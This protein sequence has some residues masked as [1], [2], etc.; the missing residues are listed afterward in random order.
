MPREHVH[1][2]RLAELIRYGDPRLAFVA[3]AWHAAIFGAL[4]FA[5][6]VV[7]WLRPATGVEAEIYASY[8]IVPPWI[9]GL[10][11][12]AGAF[13]VAYAAAGGGR[14]AGRIGTMVI[15]GG[16]IYVFVTIP[17]ASAA[18]SVWL[19][20]AFAR[21]GS[22]LAVAL[23]AWVRASHSAGW[24]GPSP[25][26][27]SPTRHRAQYAAAMVVFPPAALALLLDA[28]AAN[29][30]LEPAAW[31]A[32]GVIATA[33]LGYLGNRYGK[34]TELDTALGSEAVK[35]N[36]FLFGLYG[37]QVTDLRQQLAT[38]AAELAHVRGQ[39][40]A[41]LATRDVQDNYCRSHCEHFLHRPQAPSPPSS[42]S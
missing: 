24:L 41:H 14:H 21:Y 17:V 8:G 3:L 35:H 27:Q 20:T 30:V 2:S 31:T 19:P 37:E 28:T 6:A 18:N 13:A 22:P 15:L 10:A 42:A 34:K 40:G 32:L 1:R 39:L 25:P 33:V 12:I 11:F 36:Q 4:S 23:W 16:W 9:V 7:A 26:P 38:K 5:D 29:P